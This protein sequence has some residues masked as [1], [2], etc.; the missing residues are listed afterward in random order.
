MPR[1]QGQGVTDCRV[2]KVVNNTTDPEQAAVSAAQW[3]PH[4]DSSE[5]R[6]KH[7]LGGAAGTA[8]GR[9]SSYGADTGSSLQLEP[10]A[11]GRLG[12]ASF[13]RDFESSLEIP[14]TPSALSKLPA[15][16]DAQELNTAVFED[17]LVRQVQ[18]IVSARQ[19][20]IRKTEENLNTALKELQSVK[21][22]E[23]ALLQRRVA[24][25]TQ[26]FKEGIS[27]LERGFL[28]QAEELKQQMVAKIE[29]QK[30]QCEAA[31]EAKVLAL[32]QSLQLVPGALAAAV[33]FTPA[34]EA[35]RG[36]PMSAPRTT[37][38]EP[39]APPTAAPPTVAVSESEEDSDGSDADRRPSVPTSGSHM[40]SPSARKGS[41]WQMMPASPGRRS[42][43]HALKP[44]R[45]A[46][47][48]PV[49]VLDLL[50][51]DDD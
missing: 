13:V 21:R 20:E 16:R 18:E 33:P 44:R 47:H 5:R 15:G 2:V 26:E 40:R 50:D 3:R 7:I 25:F 48:R 32:S 39:L 29:E 46:P 9:V 37:R 43:Q 41:S 34:S 45:A 11:G 49:K 4:S 10:Y 8:G 19:Q 31:V 6:L 17:R 27:E 14:T 28:A 24:H 51:S 38:A 36:Q 23:E 1:F 30:G 42:G 22:A 35:P 12:G